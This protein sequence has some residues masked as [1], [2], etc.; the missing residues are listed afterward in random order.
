MIEGLKGGTEMF[1]V[2]CV[3]VRRWVG[4]E[5]REEVWCAGG[6][7]EKESE[8]ETGRTGGAPA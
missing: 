2:V 5:N 8:S 3:V 7:T 6:E 1:R 4:E